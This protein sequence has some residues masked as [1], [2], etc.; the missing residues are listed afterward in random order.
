[1]MD[2]MQKLREFIKGYGLTG[3]QTFSVRSLNP[4]E[5]I[6]IYD[7]DGVKIFVSWYYRYIDIIG[8]TKDEFQSLADVLDIEEEAEPKVMDLPKVSIQGAGN[9]EGQEMSGTVYKVMAE[10]E[11]KFE[12]GAIIALLRK[13]LMATWDYNIAHPKHIGVQVEDVLNFLIDAMVESMKKEKQE[14][15]K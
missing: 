2:K 8:L 13:L 4:G 5:T 9:A 3:I 6:Q 15:E 14:D 7:E 1:M 11:Y 12:I 10:M